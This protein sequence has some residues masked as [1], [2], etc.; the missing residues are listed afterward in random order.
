MIIIDMNQIS[1]ASLMMHLNMTKTKE[2]DENMVR[3]KIE[4]S[5]QLGKQQAQQSIFG[6]GKPKEVVQRTKFNGSG[7]VDRKITT[8]VTQPTTQQQQHTTSPFM[9]ITDQS[10]SRKRSRPSIQWIE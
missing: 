7:Q 2:P 6:D 1:L 8:V 3:Q 4:E 5:F 10:Q 9:T